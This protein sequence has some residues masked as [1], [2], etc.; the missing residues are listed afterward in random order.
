M[1]HLLG[2]VDHD[3]AVGTLSGGER[4]R[5]SLAR[6]LLT[7]LDLLILDEPTNHLDIEAVNWLAAHVVD[8]AGALIVVTHDR[9]F[10]DAVCTYTWEVQGGQ[11]TSYDGGYAAYVLAKAERARTAAVDRGEAAEPAEEGAR[12]AAPRR[13]GP[14]LEAEVPDRRRE[15][16]DRGR[17]AAARQARTGA[18]GDRPGSARTCSTPRTSAGR[19]SA[20]G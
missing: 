20:T 12:L 2:G 3:A 19:A 14:D 1:E 9:W 16:A 6:L 7:E 5:A 11:V 4:R 13:A 18:A 8:R 15:R 10:L 17:A